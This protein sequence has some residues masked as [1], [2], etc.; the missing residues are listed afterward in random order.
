MEDY[1][2]GIFM[3][4]LFVEPCTPF[5]TFPPGVHLS[6][7]SLCHP[8]TYP[9]LALLPL[10]HIPSV[11]SIYTVDHLPSHSD[12]KNGKYIGYCL[13]LLPGIELDP[14]RVLGVEKC[15][16]R[17]LLPMYSNRPSQLVGI[18]MDP[19]TFIFKLHWVSST[20][21]LVALA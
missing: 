9:L 1:H 14:A 13:E 2:R 15:R 19:G 3:H 11:C 16:K 10:I 12:V 17:S 6:L 5:L 18:Q 21:L 20:G 7:C 8:Y 4:L